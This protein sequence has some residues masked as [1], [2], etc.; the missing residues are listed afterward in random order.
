MR[1]AMESS[2]S[3]REIEHEILRLVLAKLHV[4]RELL[5]RALSDEDAPAW[6]QDRVKAAKAH[7]E[8][9]IAAAESYID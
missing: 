9:A 4:A 2:E 5:Q 3:H 1:R 8:R 7:L 6:E